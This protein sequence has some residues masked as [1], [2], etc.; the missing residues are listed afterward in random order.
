[1]RKTVFIGPLRRRNLGRTDAAASEDRKREEKDGDFRLHNHGSFCFNVGIARTI[2]EGIRMAVKND[3]DRMLTMALVAALVVGGAVFARHHFHRSQNAAA[4]QLP[5]AY[6]ADVVG[7]HH[8]LAEFKGKVVLVNLWATWCPPCVAE[9][10]SLDKLQTK[11]KDRGDFRVVAIAMND[12]PLSAVT[13]FMTE[14]DLTHLDVYWDQDKQIPMKWKYA[15]IPASF[16]LDRNG[17]VVQ[18]YDGPQVW[19]TGPIFD[20][21]NAV[22][23]PPPAAQKK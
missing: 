11:F 15:G 21:I 19:D 3:F 9:M 5:D 12:P 22:L 4:G 1:V 23:N 14:K 16:L 8:T 7:L 20:K 2:V 10:P 18:R 13:G 6:F 17:N